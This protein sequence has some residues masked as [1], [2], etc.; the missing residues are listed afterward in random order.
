MY[1]NKKAVC[2]ASMTLSRKTSRKIM[3]LVLLIGLTFPVFAQNNQTAKSVLEGMW[4]DANGPGFSTLLNSG[5]EMSRFRSMMGELGSARTAYTWVFQGN[6][7][8]Y[9]P[10][11]FQGLSP[12]TGED[13]LNGTFVV[14][15]AN[16]RFTVT[17]RFGDKYIFQYIVDTI[18]TS[19]PDKTLK[20]LQIKANNGVISTFYAYEERKTSSAPTSPPASPSRPGMGTTRDPEFQRQWE[21]AN[22]DI[23]NPVLPPGLVLPSGETVEERTRSG[24]VSGK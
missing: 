5:D 23:H 14:D 17:D 19:Q 13:I 4:I 3:V 1:R 12:A 22:K 21:E 11:V 9:L 18:K 8:R 15:I 7:C 16:K 10:I 2:G 20:R 24:Q 6:N